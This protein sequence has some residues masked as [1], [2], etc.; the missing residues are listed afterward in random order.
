MPVI[1]ASGE[2]V[3][4]AVSATG[5]ATVPV[6]ATPQV[7]VPVAQGVSLASGDPAELI[8]AH[9]TSDTAH[10]S[11][12]PQF[13]RVVG[14]AAATD[15]AATTI[16]VATPTPEATGG[17]PD[18]VVPDGWTVQAEFT[19]AEFV[20]LQPSLPCLLIPNGPNVGLWH[21][22]ASGPWEQVPV[23]T[24]QQVQ[25]V[26]G[27]YSGFP[28]SW[29]GW[30]TDLIGGGA[31]DVDLPPT[32]FVFESVDT[33]WV[34]FPTATPGNYFDTD[35]QRWVA[36]DEVDDYVSVSGTRVL[37]EALNSLVN[38]QP[39][40]APVGHVLFVPPE[41]DPL[42]N[43][44]AFPLTF[45][46]ETV[47]AQQHVLV[48]F[49][50][51]DPRSGIYLARDDQ[52][53]LKVHPRWNRIP[54]VHVDNVDSPHDRTRWFRSTHPN[55]ASQWVQA[56][57]AGGA[58]GWTD[59]FDE[60]FLDNEVKVQLT[61]TGLTR[62]SWSFAG[63]STRNAA[64]DTLRL[65]VNDNRTDLIYS[66]NAGT[67]VNALGLALS[68]EVPGVLTNSDRAGMFSGEMHLL[69]GFRRSGWSN[70]TSHLSSSTQAG[71]GRIFGHEIASS[72]PINTIEFFMSVG[73][74]AA[75]SRLIV[76][77]R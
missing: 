70:A 39:W 15:G 30:N 69:E 36:P 24:G 62:V 17:S 20:T 51:G 68:N 21:V 19:A 59:L 27:A 6:A 73:S 65:T 5:S 57:P 48:A 13:A 33:E 50:D 14:F 45:G 16:Y 11:R 32:S 42:V 4:V 61:V 22:T 46:A 76:S 31:P 25:V 77:A 55:R 40:S 38:E 8:D 49:T 43:P 34:N 23:A 64:A 7:Q 29:H 26:A 9:N 67:G 44:G 60:T 18:G 10:G 63:R 58:G 71:N 75:G 52:K 72:A 54:W 3:N 28:A 35:D 2:T 74:I 66:T 47:V 53:W 1:G 56:L 12:L 41:F 37:T